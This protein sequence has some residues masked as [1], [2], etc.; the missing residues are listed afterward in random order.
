MAVVKAKALNELP[1]IYIIYNINS[2]FDGSNRLGQQKN[3]DKK[4]IS[5]WVAHSLPVMSR[6]F[7]RL[8]V[9]IIVA[10][11]KVSY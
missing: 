4:Y 1:S 8:L 9:L 10:V 7:D 11:P 6:A 5:N 2:L 3:R